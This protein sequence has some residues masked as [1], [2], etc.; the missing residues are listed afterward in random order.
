MY[1]M[2][3]YLPVG[4]V[5]LLKNGK[6]RVMV[7]GFLATAPETNGKMFDYMG[8]LYPEG[9]ISSDKNLLFNHGQIDKVFHM[10]Y[11][12]EEWKE[13]ETKVKDLVEK[14]NI[15][16]G[17]TVPTEV[18]VPSVQQPVQQTNPSENMFKIEPAPVSAVEPVQQPVQQAN[19]SENM[20]KINADFFQ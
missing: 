19:S 20:F 17:E 13:F 5:V 4:T 18:A 1:N 10:G 16:T 11:V 6:K 3:K 9:V 7:T 2:E 15:V 12:D 14:S 8:C